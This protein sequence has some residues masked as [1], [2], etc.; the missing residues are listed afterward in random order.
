MILERRFREKL[1]QA[2]DAHGW[3]Q[4]DLARAMGVNRQYVSKYLRGHAS[5]GLDVIQ[6]FAEALHVDPVN[7]LDQRKIV[8]T[9]QV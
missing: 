5:P 6:R 3:K 9:S 7:L 8:V 4:S 1:Q 2:I